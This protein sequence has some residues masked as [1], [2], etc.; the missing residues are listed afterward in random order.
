MP[1][2]PQNVGE[3]RDS[4][5]TSGDFP[6]P[7][8]KGR[9]SLLL[10]AA[11]ATP[12]PRGSREPGERPRV[13]CVCVRLA[14]SVCGGANVSISVRCV[15]VCVSGVCARALMWCGVCMCVCGVCVYGLCAHGCV[16]AR[17]FMWS[18]VCA[19]M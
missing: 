16:C 5:A 2:P 7:F 1:G 13:H 19:C 6:V 18:G 12:P 15:Y 14:V 4:T 3:G 11:A 17:A 9:I 8:S 10:G